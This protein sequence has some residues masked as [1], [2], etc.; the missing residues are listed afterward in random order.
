MGNVNFITELMKI[1]ILSKKVGPDCLK[2]LYDRCQKVDLDKTLRELTIEAI[3]VFTE[4]F[5][6]II[7]EEDKSIKAKDKEE[8]Q[9]K[10]DDIF[11]KLEKIISP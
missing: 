3:I 5:G 7:Y 8:Y 6:R 1:K 10:I 4:K 11:K 9:A 2:N